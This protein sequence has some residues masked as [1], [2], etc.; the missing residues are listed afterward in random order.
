MIFQTITTGHQ[1]K[2]PELDAEVTRDVKLH[3]STMADKKFPAMR[4]VGRDSGRRYDLL[5]HSECPGRSC[6]AAFVRVSARRDNI[7]ERP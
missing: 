4:F 5:F 1:Q 2:V 7:H 3:S 6:G